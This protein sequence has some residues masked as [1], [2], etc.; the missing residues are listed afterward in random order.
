MGH[1]KSPCLVALVER[2]E[3]SD[4]AANESLLSQPSVFVC[5]LPNTST[6]HFSLFL[7]VLIFISVC[8]LCL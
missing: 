6:S 2:G 5:S 1:G 8:F 7:S 3:S 4:A